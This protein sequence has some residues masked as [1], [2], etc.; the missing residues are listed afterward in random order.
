MESVNDWIEKYKP[1]KISDIIGNEKEVDMISLWLKNFDSQKEKFFK[2]NEAKNEKKKKKNKNPSKQKKNNEV[3]NSDL[4]N[5]TTGQ[6]NEITQDDNDIEGLENYEV[7]SHPTKFS[8][9]KMFSSSLISGNHG[10]GKTSMIKAILTDLGYEIEV[11]NMYNL[12]SNKNIDDK[13]NKITKSSNIFDSFNGSKQAKKKV[14]IIDELETISNSTEKKFVENILRSNDEKWFFPIICI[15]SSKHTKLITTLKNSTLRIK[16]NQPTNNDM[17]ELFFKIIKR[18]KFQFDSKNTMIKIR[19][20]AQFDFRRL[21]YTLY[22]FKK[23][24]SKKT[25]TEVDVNKYCDISKTKDTDIDI[26][27]STA[28]LILNYPGMDECLRLY[29]GEKVILPLMIH[30]NYPKCMIEYKNNSD[31][32][33]KLATELSESIATGDI[34]ENYI[35]S[36]QNWDMQDVHCFYTCINPSVQLSKLNIEISPDYLKTHVDFPHVLNRT[37]IEKINKRNFDN[38]NVFLKNMNINDFMY[39]NTFTNKLIKD[40]KIE[41]CAQIYKS[42]SAKAETIISVLKIDKIDVD[43]SQCPTNIK[44][45]FNKYL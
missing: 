24:F 21:L 34:I 9:S 10:I 12:S 19:N 25:I 43:K 20:H 28:D 2:E 14:V 17:D 41:E 1:R 31:N 35:Y 7:E 36:E 23:C 44:K 29:S 15:S 37:S 8:K 13:L 30:Q 16:L 42:Y 40:K 11:I 5:S 18:E 22:D 26:Y 39:A 32:M 45:L 33:L 3:Q 27:K 6:N 4:N 38:A